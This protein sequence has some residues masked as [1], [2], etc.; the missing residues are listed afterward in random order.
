[1]T[2]HHREKVCGEKNS[3]SEKNPPVNKATQQR[4]LV[5]GQSRAVRKESP[6]AKTH[7]SS[8]RRGG[9]GEVLYKVASAESRE[10]ADDYPEEGRGGG[11]SIQI[12]RTGKR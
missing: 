3:L 5:E 7:R 9:G 2:T 8:Y 10:G 6:I 12:R 4:D 1:V 11:T